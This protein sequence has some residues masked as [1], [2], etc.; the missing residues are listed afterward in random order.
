VDNQFQAVIHRISTD[1]QFHNRFLNDFDAAISSFSLS[2][3][4]VNILAAM[5]SE[6]MRDE[7]AEPDGPYGWNWS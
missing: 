2:K 4:D 3:E 6:F 1:T 7:V 5:R